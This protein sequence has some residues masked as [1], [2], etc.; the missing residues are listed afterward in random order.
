M[1]KQQA[2]KRCKVETITALAECLG[3]TQSAVSQWPRDK[4]PKLYEL[5]ILYELFPAKRKGAYAR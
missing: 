4:I 1:T 2:M 5:R 3:V